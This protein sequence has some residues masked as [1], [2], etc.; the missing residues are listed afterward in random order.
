MSTPTPPSTS[1]PRP[2]YS[3]HPAYGKLFGTPTVAQRREAMRRF[4][5]EFRKA[6][7]VTRRTRKLQ[8]SVSGKST[9]LY[10]KLKR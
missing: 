1:I 2:D 5:P 3:N 9:P 8:S 4:L 10:E 6:W 7:Q